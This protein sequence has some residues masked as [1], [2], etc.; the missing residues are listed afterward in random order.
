VATFAIQLGKIPP[1]ILSPDPIAEVG[2]NPNLEVE[3][4]RNRGE[5]E[6]S[7]KIQ[8]IYQINDFDDDS[9]QSPVIS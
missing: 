2:L 9:S 5:K 8:L 4:G 7:L 6:L 1:E 3:T